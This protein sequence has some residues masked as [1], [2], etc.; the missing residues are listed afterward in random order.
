MPADDNDE[1]RAGDDA[2][3][4]DK[5]SASAPSSS[6]WLTS[7]GSIDHGRFQP[8]E[9]LEGRYRVLGLLGR[10]GM[11]EVYRADDLRLGQQVALK[12]LPQKLS[13][14]PARLAQFHNEVRTAR[15]VSHQNVC[16]VY[17]IG[18]LPDADGGAPHLFITMEYVDGED[19]SALLR[20][21]GRFPEDKA[22]EIARQICAGLTAAHDRG[23]LHRDLK[24]A[25]IMLD[26]AGR[27]RLMDFG[28]ASIGEVSDVRAGTPAYM[29]PEQ[30]H[31]REVTT[32][33]DIFALGLVLHELFTGRRVF[34]AA[35]IGE[36]VTQH[37][38]GVST[39]VSE[40][41]KAV[42]PTVER[43]IARCLNP[44]PAMRPASAQ[45]VAAQLS[46][47]PL[48][49][50]IAAG[51]TP[52]PE[53]VA[54]AGGVSAAFSVRMGLV[55]VTAGLLLLLLVAGLA[56][57]T[58]MPARIPLTKPVAV[59]LDRAQELRVAF[60]YTEPVADQASGFRYDVDYLNWA[61]TKIHASTWSTLPTGRPAAAWF[62]YRTSPRPL[63][64]YGDYRSV[65]SGDPPVLISGMVNVDL[66]PQGRLVQ[67]IAVP[68]QVIAAPAG[69]AT[70][71][72]A[73]LFEAAALPFDAFSEAPPIWTPRSHAD[74]QR[75]WIGTVAELPGETLR[76][77]AS[78][79]QGR[80]T[81]FT[82]VGPWTRPTRDVAFQ[83]GGTGQFTGLIAALIVLMLPFGAGLLARHNLRTGRGDHR[84]AMTLAVF[85]FFLSLVLWLLG[86]DHFSSLD[87]EVNRF[88]VA[89][90]MALFD[91]AMLYAIYLAVE[92]YVRRAWPAVLITW[93]RI[94]T[95]ASR[96]DPLV[97][98]DLVIG[99]VLGLLLT[100]L[101]SAYN[102]LPSL[103]GQPEPLPTLTDITILVGVR[104]LVVSVGQQ[105]QW[106]LQNSLVAVLVLAVPRFVITRDLGII[107]RDWMIAAVVTIIFMLVSSRNA[108]IGSGYLWFELAYS[109]LLSLLLVLALMR[110]GL[111][112]LTVTFFSYQVT[113][114]ALLTLDRTRLYAGASTTVLA[115]I[116]ALLVWGYWM[117]RGGQSL[118]EPEAPAQT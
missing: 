16:R 107:K 108:G 40:V 87:T 62:W 49:A 83:A 32:R 38:T 73:R 54:A 28:L 50:A 88:F 29:A 117:A 21:I 110:F 89:I 103:V 115:L 1:T 11:G 45:A 52:S 99:T 51:E 68:P 37:E 111:F 47:D 35:T 85:V 23:I 5:A 36:L 42:D 90:G 20:R 6:G 2:T 22:V 41:A 65:Q 74:E 56:D 25:N 93:A 97:G 4:L 26:G 86:T 105:L 101:S 71:D 95:A 8:G 78:G 76:V 12:F 31:G 114:S 48:A 98:R 109:G 3:R 39:S 60:G 58:T 77:E 13:Q 104:Q 92:P 46:A 14:D 19:L 9:V 94:S 17:D 81:S 64:P 18:E 53:M 69:E 43:V 27:V 61:S 70:V 116:A 102:I 34:T 106:A 79:Y 84:G 57:R 30:L 72:W 15:Q 112:G 118:F 24:P 91:G 113:S 10:G 80:P 7:S 75:A 100:A 44:D 55:W 33:S 66:D 96:R 67:F 59:L 82:I 63:V